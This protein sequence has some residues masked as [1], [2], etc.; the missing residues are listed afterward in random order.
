MDQEEYPKSKKSIRIKQPKT[1]DSNTFHSFPGMGGGTV[2]K[3][4]FQLDSPLRVP[5]C[6]KGFE[7]G[8]SPHK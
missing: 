6:A 4:F 1:L 8:T 3:H 2:I 5:W 7:Q